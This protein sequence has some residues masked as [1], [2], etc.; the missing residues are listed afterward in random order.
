MPIHDKDEYLNNEAFSENFSNEVQGHYLY[1]DAKIKR[2]KRQSELGEMIPGP[3]AD[4]VQ[5]IWQGMMKAMVDGAK[6]I[7]K[8]VAEGLDAEPPSDYSK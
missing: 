6:E 4:D 8:K 2:A 3:G 5:N 1:N 7:V